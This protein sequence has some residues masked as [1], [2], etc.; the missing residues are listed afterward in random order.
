M[1]RLTSPDGTT[2]GAAEAWRQGVDELPAE[3]FA[4]LDAGL[5]PAL[6][7][8][9][10]GA[11]HPAPDLGGKAGGAARLRQGVRAAAL[12]ARHGYRDPELLLAAL[13]MPFADPG[14][15]GHRELVATRPRVTG[16][17]DAILLAAVDAQ[18]R[19]GQDHAGAWRCY[20]R[21][22]RALPPELVALVVASRRAWLETGPPDQRDRFAELT[23]DLLPLAGEL[24]A[25]LRAEVSRPFSLAARL[26]GAGRT[27]GA[28][29]DLAANPVTDP[30]VAVE[31][32][33]RFEP[34]WP[35]ER[36][37]VAEYDAGYLV[38]LTG[39]PVSPHPGGRV[40][41]L[42][43]DRETRVVSS[44]WDLSP[45][46]AMTA[47]AARHQHFPLPPGW[48]A[49]GRGPVPA[50]LTDA[51]TL[52]PD[53]AGAGPELVPGQAGLADA[54]PEL[55]PVRDHLAGYYE[56]QLSAG[57]GWPEFLSRWSRGVIA[58]SLLAGAGVREP[59]PLRAALLAPFGA[60]TGDADY[61]W[62]RDA[63]RA[64]DPAAAELLDLARW[65]ELPPGGSAA[66]VAAARARSLA[67]APPGAR[68]VAVA[69]RLAVAEYADSRFGGV[70]LALRAHL[71]RMLPLV[72]DLPELHA[73]A[74]RRAGVNTD[75]A[76]GG[77]T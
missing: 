34:G 16:W 10:R 73:A 48:R 75:E 41:A 18:P 46:H 56:L 31:L 67:A 19:P 8:L 13:L 23:G 33:A 58:V 3:A 32:A 14:I 28:S 42:I 76:P 4:A 64:V 70:C 12:L 45:E 35:R 21:H 39:V 7:R 53:P 47:Y 54:G 44:W 15:G 38:W 52:A 1:V 20:L 24:P 25:G 77:V 2:A 30:D 72:A 37:A 5:L 68:W 65:P 36:L 43:V 27:A 59:A 6:E 61:R 17:S 40:A 74:A 26:V 49:A 71:G 57:E 66:V 29:P 9:L 60:G 51:L 11:G 55:A 50:G 22:V 69:D 62:H 63:L